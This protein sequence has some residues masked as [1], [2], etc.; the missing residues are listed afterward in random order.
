[1]TLWIIDKIL[2][3]AEPNPM[4]SSRAEINRARIGKPLDKADK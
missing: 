3:R 4:W 2:H 1:M